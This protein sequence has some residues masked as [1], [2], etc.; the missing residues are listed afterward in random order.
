M[1]TPVYPTVLMP[2]IAPCMSVIDDYFFI[3]CEEFRSVRASLF[4]SDFLSEI[5]TSGDGKIHAMSPPLSI[6]Q[7]GGFRNEHQTDK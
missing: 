1:D 4:P 3:S 2:E 5:I 7:E 6:H